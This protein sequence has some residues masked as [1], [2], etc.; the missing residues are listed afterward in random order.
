MATEDPGE[1]EGRSTR[2]RYWQ[3]VAD[4]LPLCLS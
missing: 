4:V 3:L 2:E 1:G